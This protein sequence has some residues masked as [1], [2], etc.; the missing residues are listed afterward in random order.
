MEIDET[1]PRFVVTY[2]ASEDSELGDERRLAATISD[3][4]PQA[5]LQPD[6][7]WFIHSDLTAQAIL[8]ELSVG[9][10]EDCLMICE[11]P[12]P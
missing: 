10:S 2:A 7:V 3:A 4:F 12:G 6:G 8:A 9:I 11:I 1:V 5:E